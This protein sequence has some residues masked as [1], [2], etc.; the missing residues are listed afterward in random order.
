MLSDM[1]K[2]N[3]INQKQTIQ[4]KPN[5]KRK[6]DFTSQCIQVWLK[7]TLFLGDLPDGKTF[8]LMYRETFGMFGLSTVKT[9]L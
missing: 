9:R 1:K 6:V 3:E 4:R 7:I 5:N 8:Y 2:N